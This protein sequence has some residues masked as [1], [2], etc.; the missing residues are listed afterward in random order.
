[1]IVVGGDLAGAGSVILDPLRD[2]I[3]RAA[4]PSAAQDA[5]VTV[6]RLGDRAEV[7]GA[8]ALALRHSGRGVLPGRSGVAA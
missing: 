3:T 8:L 4:V 7:L 5:E 6:G 2:G 1:L